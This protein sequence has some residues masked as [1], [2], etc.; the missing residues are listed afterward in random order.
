MFQKPES[1]SP[2]L[3]PS[4]SQVQSAL[5]EESGSLTIFQSYSNQDSLQ[6]EKIPKSSGSR[7]APGPIPAPTQPVRGAGSTCVKLSPLPP[8][9][10]H[11]G[12]RQ[13]AGAL[14]G[15]RT[16]ASRHT[17]VSPSSNPLSEKGAD[18]RRAPVR[19]CHPVRSTKPIPTQP[20]AST[21]CRWSNGAAPFS[22]P[23]PS[24]PAAVSSW[25]QDV[26]R[27][28][29]PQACK[30]PPTPNSS[31]PHHHHPGEQA[32]RQSCSSWRRLP[33]TAFVLICGL[34][35]TTL[36]WAEWW[37]REIYVS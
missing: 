7:P 17:R 14:L 4:V 15:G 5:Q 31:F 24:A 30:G 35:K 11:G 25:R 23:R 1:G 27:I 34:Q 26:L 20:G 2:G 9:S 29:T 37:P 13:A 21:G 32:L 10:L 3:K 28:D 6:E 33:L 36:C 8:C 16:S 12:H 18:Q 22:R 19:P